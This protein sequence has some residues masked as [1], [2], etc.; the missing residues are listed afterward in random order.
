MPHTLELYTVQLGNW[1]KANARGIILVDT[2]VKSGEP[3][4][5]PTWDMVLGHKNG[6]LSDDEYTARYKAMM[7]HSMHVNP[8]QWNEL[9]NQTVV[10]LACYCSPGKFC[11]RHLLREIVLKE[12]DRR[13]ITAHHRG[14]IT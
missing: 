7:E 11:H 2:T 14:E 12:A 8:A 6:T 4:F 5:A 1:R 13:G 3:A 9:L 10:A